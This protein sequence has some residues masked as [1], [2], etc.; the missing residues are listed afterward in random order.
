MLRF[1]QDFLPQ[2]AGLAVQLLLLQFLLR[3]FFLFELCLCGGYPWG[4]AMPVAHGVAMDVWLSALVM[5]LLLPLLA[6][7]LLKARRMTVCLW[8]C[9]LWLYLLFGLL[10]GVCHFMMHRPLDHIIFVYSPAELKSVV[11]ASVHWDFRPFVLPLLA[12]AAAVP[13]LVRP[14][15]RLRLRYA[16]LLLAAMLVF[17]LVP[18]RKILGD[19]MRY[20]SREQYLLAVNQPAYTLRQWVRYAFRPDP[21]RFSAVEMQPVIRKCRGLFPGFRY[22]DS[23]YPF[24][25]LA[26]DPD[27]L[28]PFLEK[29]SDGM[30]PDFVF[31]IL[32][33]YGQELT[34]CPSTVSFTPFLDSLKRT[35]LYWENCL[36]TTE[37]TFG[38][39][40]GIFVSAPFGEKGFCHPDYP[41]PEHRSLLGDLA[42]NGYRTAFYYG[43]SAA[44]DGQGIF[45]RRNHAAC[46]TPASGGFAGNSR[47]LDC[48]R[49][50]WDDRE[51]FKAAVS[52]RVS[53]RDSAPVPHADIYLTL[54]TH[55][56]FE[57]DGIGRYMQRVDSILGQHPSV[58]SREAADIR[59]HR[60]VFACY[61]YMDD[62][63]R[64]LIGQ[65][66]KMPRY[67]NTLF[68]ITGDHRMSPL[69]G[70]NPL[71]RY[72]VPLL[73]HSPLL[74]KTKR[75][76]AVVSHWDIAPTLTAY[77]QYGY[78]L[79]VPEVSSYLGTS[80]DTAAAFRCGRRLAFMRD[81]RSVEE[82]LSD[83]F[84]L[85]GERLYRVSTS[86][87][88]VPVED[89][90]VRERLKGERS[91]FRTIDVYA[92]R[93]NLLYDEKQSPA[94]SGTE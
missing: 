17:C 51:M 90:A 68:V 2:W 60:H 75:M 85:S 42:R 73:L 36:S 44:F 77:L 62:C 16:C 24:L 49:W 78:Q 58:P 25:R 59:S 54:T 89:G 7:G 46:H 19:E 23:D 93:Q 53:E 6:F 34:G 11:T 76:E 5:V 4:I 48:H 13:L 41:M 29:T 65:Y 45:M 71:Q 69:S 82:W 20:P 9:G 35:G 32:E 88:A 92:M 61:L 81:N 8:K 18:F 84:C 52:Q 12:I 14:P 57:F 94:P 22:V 38:V 28:G 30:P 83:T 50:G 91:C 3:L 64:W 39:L 43:G 67:A 74:K 1:L 27:V 86:L 87:Q 66:S 15:F 31:L 70:G 26:D 55:E 21:G 63:I 33:G 40:P 56:P 37:R 79:S 10:L 72:H 47:M 80:L